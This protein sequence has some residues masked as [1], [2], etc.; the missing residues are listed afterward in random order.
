MG[1]C[2]M[3]RAHSAHVLEAIPPTS[4][5]EM[6]QRMRD[7]LFEDGPWWLCSFGFHTL[8]ICSLGL[9]T[10]QMAPTIVGPPEE[11]INAFSPPPPADA[12]IQIA[13]DKPI[14]GVDDPDTPAKFDPLL[15]SMIETPSNK[16]MLKDIVVEGDVAV[17]GG[18]PDGGRI[19]GKDVSPKDNPRGMV[20]RFAGPGPL[21]PRGWPHF[22]PD[23]KSDPRGNGDPYRGRGNGDGPPFGKPPKIVDR[24]IARSLT[25]LARHQLPGG[26]W[27][28]T[29]YNSR[30]KDS[31]CT[32]PGDIPSDA[33]A[34]AMGLLPF[35]GAGQTHQKGVYRKTVNGG[36][37][38]LLH[39]QKPDGD[40]RAG[41]TM[42]AHGLATIALCEAYGMSRDSAVGAAAQRAVDFICAAQNQKTGGWR[43]QPGDEGDTSV[44]GWQI[45]ALKS[46]QIAGLKVPPAVFDRT[47]LFLRSASSGVE[48]S[49]GG[50]RFGYTP[51]TG[52]TPTMTAVGLLC[53]QYMGSPRKDPAM[54][55]GTE[56]LMASQPDAATRN[57]YYWYY[58]TQ[59]MHNQPGPEWDA[60]NRKIRRILIDTQA[61]EGCAAGSWD[62]KSPSADV[63]G[64]RGGR[65]MMTSLSALTL[66][67]YY[68]YLPLYQ[69]DP[70]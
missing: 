24:A 42:Y 27:S 65:L 62:A 40:L 28:L 48:G 1:V 34:T 31:T 14:A 11:I 44:V 9:L 4:L 20:G 33:A 3:L 37:Y 19:G 41:S 21:P 69:I 45:M 68:R 6:L 35:L 57:L 43:Y 17:P 66:E 60:W 63:W 49:L 59:V 13:I 56:F 8:L 38:W 10:Y 2:A 25:W 53:F 15:A 67:V 23:G 22:G 7:W 64:T 47:R 51:G 5:R 50:G 12:S 26:G 16:S 36:I 46:A 58:A 70:E 30:C 61:K 52:A 55:D 18:D 54:V 29:T 32:G 39:N